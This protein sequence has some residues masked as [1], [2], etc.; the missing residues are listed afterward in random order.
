MYNTHS[1]VV[2]LFD[3]FYNMY[4]GKSRLVEEAKV[5]E[6]SIAS[7]LCSKRKLLWTPRVSLCPST[8]PAV[9]VCVLEMRPKMLTFSTMCGPQPQELTKLMSAEKPKRGWVMGTLR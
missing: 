3:L 7:V 2:H 9:Q 1:I 8:V 5:L 4:T 6:S